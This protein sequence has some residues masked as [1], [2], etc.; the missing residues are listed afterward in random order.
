MR[1]ILVRAKGEKETGVAGLEMQRGE[2]WRQ[3]ILALQGVDECHSPAIV[4][5]MS[6]ANCA[7]ISVQAAGCTTRE[8]ARRSTYFCYNIG[9]LPGNGI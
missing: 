5:A 6:Q 4:Y 7:S 1:V 2:Q 3:S 9:R 8:P